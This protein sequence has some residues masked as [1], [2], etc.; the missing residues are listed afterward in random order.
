MISVH[1]EK[2]IY[3]AFSVLAQIWAK[4]CNLARSP[5]GSIEQRF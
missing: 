2:D 1:N 5:Q 3:T 4:C